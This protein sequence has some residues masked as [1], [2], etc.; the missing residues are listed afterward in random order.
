MFAA[1]KYRDLTKRIH[2]T[3]LWAQ[4]ILTLSDDITN[5]LF[6]FQAI[7]IT[8]KNSTLVKREMFVS[9]HIEST[10]HLKRVQMIDDQ[11][12][13]ALF[14]SRYVKDAQQMLDMMQSGDEWFVR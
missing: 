13:T 11:F 8:L 1:S 10:D 9:C 2:I 7:Y 12:Q 6:K 4:L 14:G 5:R 3:H